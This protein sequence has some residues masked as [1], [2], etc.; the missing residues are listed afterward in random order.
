VEGEGFSR[1]HAEAAAQDDV[2]EAEV[3]L[4]REAAA[5]ASLVMSMAAAPRSARGLARMRRR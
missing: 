3:L 5:R 4:L 1:A 2:E